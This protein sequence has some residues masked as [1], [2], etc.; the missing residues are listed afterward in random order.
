M[1]S[2]DGGAALGGG[3]KPR[4]ARIMRAIIC[5]LSRYWWRDEYAL[6]SGLGRSPCGLRHVRAGYERARVVQLTLQ[7]LVLRSQDCARLLTLLERLFKHADVRITLGQ[8]SADQ[9][10]L[11]RLARRA[12]DARQA[13]EVTKGCGQLERHGVS[14]GRKFDTTLSAFV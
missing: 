2:I 10:Q 6:R 8:L 5:V 13:R 3:S 7:R 9:L 11:E 4:L 1:I 14:L 12:R